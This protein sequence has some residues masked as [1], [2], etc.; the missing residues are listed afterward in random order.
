MTTFEKNAIVS[1]YLDALSYSAN[2]FDVGKES[3][4]IALDYIFP[5]TAWASTAS[6]K[7]A[8]NETL[9]LCKALKNWAFFD[10]SVVGWIAGLYAANR[11]QVED[12]YN[13]VKNSRYTGSSNSIKKIVKLIK[14][15]VGQSMGGYYAEGHETDETFTLVRG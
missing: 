3:D 5:S 2:F 7:L 12:L 13:E 9:G 1:A 6:W 14:K 8:E 11:I 15:N 10:A 4:C